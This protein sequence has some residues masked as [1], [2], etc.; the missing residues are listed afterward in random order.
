MTHY[1]KHKNDVI[2]SVGQPIKILNQIG[3]VQWVAGQPRAAADNDCELLVER[4]EGGLRRAV[5]SITSSIMC[6]WS[7]PLA[8]AAAKRGLS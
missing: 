8:T 2:T 5:L 3:P 4:R 1:P 6:V 7:P